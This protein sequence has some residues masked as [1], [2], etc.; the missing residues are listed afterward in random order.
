MKISKAKELE[1]K[2]GMQRCYEEMLL[3]LKGKL[4]FLGISKGLT[5]SNLKRYLN[6]NLKN[7]EQG[8]YE[9]HYRKIAKEEA[10]TNE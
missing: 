8:L 3:D 7:I 2:Y 9:E 5:E 1:F 6:K 10:T 4:M